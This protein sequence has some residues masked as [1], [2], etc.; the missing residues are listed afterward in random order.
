MG[1]AGA[2]VRSWVLRHILGSTVCPLTHRVH[3]KLPEIAR[4]IWACLDLQSISIH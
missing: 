2:T 4:I 1:R 3:K